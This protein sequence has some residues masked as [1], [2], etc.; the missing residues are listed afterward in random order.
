M[1]DAAVCGGGGGVAGFAVTCGQGY[2]G[3]APRLPA[4]GWVGQAGWAGLAAAASFALIE[5]ALARLDG[6]LVENGEIM[7]EA[8]GA[9]V[10]RAAGG[11]GNENG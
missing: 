9:Q 7:P 6:F 8:R 1:A 10:A 3:L 4:G 11:R 5:A 2:I